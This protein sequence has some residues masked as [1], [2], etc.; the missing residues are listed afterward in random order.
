MSRDTGERDAELLT[1]YVDGVAE[2]SADERRRVSAR[3][4][5][6]P[7]A[8]ADEAA[9]RSLLERLRALPPEPGEPDWAVLE[10]SIQ[11]AVGS[12]L[13]RPWWRRWRWLA[14]ATTLATAALVLLVMWARPPATEQ[15]PA[16]DR[17]T[18][19]ARTPIGDD[20]VALWLDGAEVDVDLS[21][22]DMLGESL[23][24]DDEPASPE[25]AGSHGPELLPT[26]DLAW[27]D[28]LDDDAL[29]RAERWL[30]GASPRRSPAKG[31]SPGRDP[32]KS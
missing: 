30:A 25:L 26:T 1:A 17:P 11:H 2:L 12:D 7:E 31:R 9:V 29:D 24:G 16:S 4:A 20:V 19:P 15:T 14:P 27:V 32:G 23:A 22:S 6:D 18:H 13:P 8:R 3:L 21:A 28:H 10:R 5:R